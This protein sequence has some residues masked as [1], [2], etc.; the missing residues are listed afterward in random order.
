MDIKSI[1]MDGAPSALLGSVALWWAV[2]TKK[3][4][5]LDVDALQ[6]HAPQYAWVTYTNAMSELIQLTATTI[7]ESK[8]EWLH[9]AQHHVTRYGDQ[10]LADLTFD[11]AF[12]M[13]AGLA[14][15]K[16]LTFRV[17]LLH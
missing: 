13:V 3:L 14:A 12:D 2:L 4:V 1:P 17:P 11:A 6:R 16:P 5:S 10:P 7:T 9:E 8:Q 15:C